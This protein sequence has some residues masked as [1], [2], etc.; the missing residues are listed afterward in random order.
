MTA[1]FKSFKAQVRSNDRLMR[2][3]SKARTFK[4][5]IQNAS[6]QTVHQSWKANVSD[7]GSF[8]YLH[9]ADS[10]N[11]GDRLSLILTQSLSDKKVL[12]PKNTANFAGRPVYSC[13]GSVLQWP[14][15]NALQIWGSGFIES[16]GRLIFPPKA[17]HAVR[18]RLTRQNI[19]NQG[20]YCP[21]IYGDPAV[22]AFD[23]YSSHP[24]TREFK[25]GIIPHYADKSHP[26]I[27]RLAH[28]DNVLVMDV[29]SD[30]NELC[31]NSL[32]CDTIVSSSLH[33]LILS[34]ALG[35]P[36]R[37]L[38]VSDVVLKDQFKF[39][40]YFSSVYRDELFLPSSE[41][42]VGAVIKTAHLR[43]KPFPRTPLLEACPFIA[44]G[45]KS[46]LQSIADQDFI[47]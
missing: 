11:F 3:I 36:N 33:G 13:V 28:Q 4:N 40:D 38:G 34:D 27:Q 43:H 39:N 7:S 14:E 5:L 18:G 25:V 41:L 44:D 2:T 16:S 21:D 20:F 31:I 23:Q 1:L 17:V 8:L 22:L 9:W 42:T 32:K 47:Q 26:D 45:Y 37:W 6:F 46:R 30:W 19:L 12:S 29:F 10:F 15:S 24:R 35:I